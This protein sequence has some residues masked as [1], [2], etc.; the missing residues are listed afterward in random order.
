MIFKRLIDRIHF[1]HD[2]SSSHIP[3]LQPDPSSDT[4]NVRNQGRN[5]KFSAPIIAPIS[6]GERINRNFSSGDALSEV[7]KVKKL[8]GLENEILSFASSPINHSLDHINEIHDLD[9]EDL[10]LH[11]DHNTRQLFRH[12][13][14]FSG[15]LQQLN[16]MRKY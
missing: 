6:R 13:N 15:I 14:H 5:R 10:H 4:S 11:H 8:L 7:G 2:R 1:S 9:S 16:E 12:M 3:S